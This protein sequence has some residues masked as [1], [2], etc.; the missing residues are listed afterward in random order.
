MKEYTPFQSPLEMTQAE[1][2]GMK[3]GQ[4]KVMEV[5]NARIKRSASHDEYE[6][7]SMHDEQRSVKDIPADLSKKDLAVLKMG[8][9]IPEKLSKKMSGGRSTSQ[10][11][12]Y[13]V[14]ENNIKSAPQFSPPK[15]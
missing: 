11:N 15:K 10:E 9:E 4:K 3:A 8:G 2:E 12:T 13:T 7:S 1:V 5:V 14:E 6:K